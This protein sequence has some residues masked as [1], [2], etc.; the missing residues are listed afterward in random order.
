MI[1]HAQEIYCCILGGDSVG[2]IRSRAPCDACIVPL[3]LFYS[4][5]PWASHSGRRGKP[6]LE[7]AKQT[8]SEIGRT[9]G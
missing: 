6:K 1:L 3:L 9:V 2:H 4:E 8:G 7:L 5:T